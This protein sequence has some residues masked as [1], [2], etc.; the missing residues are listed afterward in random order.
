[1]PLAFLPLL[2]LPGTFGVLKARFRFLRN[3]VVYHKAETLHHAFKTS[4]CLHNMILIYD[5]RASARER[6]WEQVDWES[7]DPDADDEDD[8]TDNEAEV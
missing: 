4:C 7:L 5:G 3:G 8:I 2:L 6:L 1:M